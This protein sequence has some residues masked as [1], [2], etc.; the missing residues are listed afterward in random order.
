M[1]ER[2]ATMFTQDWIQKVGSASTG[3]D[4]HLLASGDNSVAVRAMDSSRSLASSISSR[5]DNKEGTNNLSGGF[6]NGGDEEWS[7]PLRRCRCCCLWLP[8]CGCMSRIVDRLHEWSAREIL[9]LTKKPIVY[10][11]KD[12]S[13]EELNT[14]IR[15]ML[16]NE[17][18]R[19]IK[20][21]RV[22]PSEDSLPEELPSVYK[23]LEFA[24]P[25]ILI[26]YTAMVGINFGPECIHALSY[27]MHVPTTFMFMGSFSDKFEFS[28]TE[29]GGLRLITDNFVSCCC[30]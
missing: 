11:T 29:L 14:A 4:S 1:A 5:D 20:F 17:Q 26:E 19:W 30:R 8:C 18:R 9:H 10:F 22:Y 21:V 12:D 28:F 15:Y 13:P 25:E 16:N 27:H 2:P 23:F 7:A 6:T 3:V 24:Y